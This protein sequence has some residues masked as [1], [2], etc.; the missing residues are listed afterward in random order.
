MRFTCAKHTSNFPFNE[1]EV[2]GKQ[3]QYNFSFPGLMI[4]WTNNSPLCRQTL[5]L[6]H[7]ST[8]FTLVTIF[9]GVGDQVTSFDTLQTSKV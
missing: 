4:G 7:K 1:V 8:S 5:K 9:P 6:Q 3:S 2:D